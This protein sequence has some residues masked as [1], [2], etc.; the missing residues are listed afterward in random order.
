MTGTTELTAF[1]AHLPDLEPGE[2]LKLAATQ[3]SADHSPLDRAHASARMAADRI[4]STAQLF[5]LQDEILHWA[6]AKGAVSGAW[7]GV[8]DAPLLLADARRQAVPAL[9][10]AGTA[11][12]LGDALDSTSRGV[13]TR[14]WGSLG[15]MS[16]AS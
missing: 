7:A 2:L 6:E 8:A 9:V 11:F 13:L 14:A 4:G 12:L 16:P 5:D 3:R 10:D 15:R 1:L